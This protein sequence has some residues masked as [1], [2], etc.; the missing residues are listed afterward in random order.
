MTRRSSRCWHCRVGHLP[1]FNGR[2]QHPAC[3]S[4][5]RHYSWSFVGLCKDLQP[6]EAENRHLGCV[7]TH[8]MNIL[9]LFTRHCAHL[10]NGIQFRHCRIYHQMCTIIHIYSAFFSITHAHTHTKRDGDNRSTRIKRLACKPVSEEGMSVLRLE[11]MALDSI[12][13]FF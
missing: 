9:L 4:Y 10:A 6:V 11:P 8:V 3:N 7:G 13:N 1:T 12:D 2:F 5:N